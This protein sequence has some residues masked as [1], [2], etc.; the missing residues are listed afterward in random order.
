M[1]LSEIYFPRTLQELESLLNREKN[2][3]IIGGATSF[4]YL[5]ETSYLIFEPSI[6]CIRQ[7]PEIIDD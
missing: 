7:I 6:A 4:G 5:Q 3:Q 2:I 1:N